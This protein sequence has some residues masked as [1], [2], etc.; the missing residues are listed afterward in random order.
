MPKRNITNADL[1]LKLAYGLPHVSGK[2]IA[3]FSS[4]RPSTQELYQA[5]A[6]A[7]MELALYIRRRAEELAPRDIE[8]KDA[9]VRTALEAVKVLGNQIAINSLKASLTGIIPVVAEEEC[10]D[11][12]PCPKNTAA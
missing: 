3:A 4:R 10:K 1:D 11:D 12:E 8:M 5:I 2:V 9:I 7:N 6:A